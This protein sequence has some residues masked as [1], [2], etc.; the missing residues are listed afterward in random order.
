MEEFD[1]F[2]TNNRQFVEDLYS[3]SLLTDGYAQL[4][5][6]ATGA[7]SYGSMGGGGGGMFGARYGAGAYGGKSVHVKPLEDILSEDIEE[8]GADSEVTHD[9]APDVEVSSEDSEEIVNNEDSLAVDDDGETTES[10]H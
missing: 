4:G 6:L 10:S 9:M 2:F 8:E 3:G 7:A 5:G 1:A